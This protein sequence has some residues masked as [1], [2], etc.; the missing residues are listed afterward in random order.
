MT[1]M[2][3]ATIVLFSFSP[4]RWP[5]KFS[6]FVCI[7]RGLVKVYNTESKHTDVALGAAGRVTASFSREGLPWGM[8]REQPAPDAQASVQGLASPDSRVR[9]DK[10]GKY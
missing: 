10:R 9:I 3:V 1:G 7:L 5:G 8:G 4:R 2:D 6:L